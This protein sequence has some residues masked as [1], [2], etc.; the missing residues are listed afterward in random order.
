MTNPTAPSEKL[1]YPD[2]SSVSERLIREAAEKHIS[3]AANVN[4]Q[5]INERIQAN[6]KFNNNINII[7]DIRNYYETETNN[8][9]KKLSRYKN[10][11][12]IAEITEIVLSQ[13]ATTA[14]KTTSVSLTG[15]E[16]AYSIPTAF[17]TA[18]VCGSLSKTINTKIRNKTIKYSQMYILSKH[19]SDKFN[20][21]YTKSMNENKIDNDEYNEFVK[22]YE[23]Y[24]KNKK[25]KLSIFLD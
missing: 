1:L 19:F 21:L 13:I 16:L 15:I 4:E 14:T 23:D 5:L 17:G 25:K 10:Y 18:T 9:N 22:L 2:L 6:N 12:N 8:Y 11:I 20:I 24:K 3:N 7:K